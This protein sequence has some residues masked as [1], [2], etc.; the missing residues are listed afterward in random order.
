MPHV[1]AVICPNCGQ[2]ARFEFAEGRSV[3][4]AHRQWFHR[5]RS[6]ELQKIQ[7]SGGARQVVA[8]HYPGLRGK[9]LETIDEFPPG[10]S[11]D[12]WRHSQYLVRSVTGQDGTLACRSCDVRRK[13]RLRWPNDAWFQIE[14]RGRLLWAFDRDMASRLLAYIE[15]KIR[16]GPDWQ[17]LKVPAHFRSAKAR[18]EVAKRLR[19]RLFH[20]SK[21]PSRHRSTH[22]KGR[23]LNRG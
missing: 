15:G 18:D 6:F 5:S 10:H 19:A 11:A 20:G 23:R 9:S 7:L 13:H 14:Y 4:R 22:S 8:M 3:N 2:E 16:P 12:N 21:R 17:L 1:L